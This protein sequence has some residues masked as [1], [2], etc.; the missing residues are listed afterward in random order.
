MRIA[1]LEDD[2]AQTELM[3]S[4]LSEAGHHCHDYATGEALR[5]ALG[6]DTY[7]LLIVDWNLPDT[8]GIEV[9]RWVRGELDWD[10]PVLFITSRDRE[11]DIVTAL[12]AG[13]D[14][15][16]TKPPK[17]GETLARLQALGRR[18]NVQ[19]SQVDLQEF[20]PYVINRAQRQLLVDGEPVEL[21][22]KEF[23][24]VV[25]LFHNIGRL[26]SRSYMMET[27]WGTSV[28]LNT[29]TVDTHVSRVRN[30]LGLRPERG[31]RL[32]AVYHHGYRLEQVDAGS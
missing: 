12:N 2:P 26:L 9:V 6:H 1:L 15:Y 19:E 17:Q 3:Q 11:E 7:D 5:T 27:I 13:A 31:W 29:R 16:M 22:H 8:S 21:T 25:L 18:G 24:L 10:I 20:P 4:W 23:E 14:D 30:K 32:S 28:E